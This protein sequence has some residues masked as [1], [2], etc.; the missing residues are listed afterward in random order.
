MAAQGNEIAALKAQLETTNSVSDTV[1]KALDQVK[2]VTAQPAQQKSDPVNIDQLVDSRLE[3]RFAKQKKEANQK[4]LAKGLFDRYGSK[5][6]VKSAVQE[7]SSTLGVSAE[8]LM[9]MA[10]ES[11]QM[12]LAHFKNG[13]PKQDPIDKLTSSI[14]NNSATTVHNDLPSNRISIGQD[15]SDGNLS[16][17]VEHFLGQMDGGKSIPRVKR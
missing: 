4:E 10:E 15:S 9:K 11:P 12:V 5:D 16:N 2:T 7:V 14:N 13:T 1:S 6:A 17:Y 3:A 8:K